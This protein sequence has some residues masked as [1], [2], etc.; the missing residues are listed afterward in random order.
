MRGRKHYEVINPVPRRYIETWSK[1]GWAK[2]KCW[3][4]KNMYT[5]VDCLFIY[6]VVHLQNGKARLHGSKPLYIFCRYCY[7]KLFR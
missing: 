7:H 1:L 6:E 3:G 5:E 4:C 2:R